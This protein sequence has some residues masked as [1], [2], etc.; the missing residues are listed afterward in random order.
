MLTC[1]FSGCHDLPRYRATWW[2]ELREWC[3]GKWVI[4]FVDYW[5]VLTMTR[6]SKP[7]KSGMELLLTLVCDNIPVYASLANGFIGPDP[8]DLSQLWW[9][10][11]QAVGKQ[12]HPN[13]QAEI[14]A[15]V[16]PCGHK[17]SFLSDRLLSF[18]YRFDM[19]ID[20]YTGL[21]I[22]FYFHLVWSVTCIKA[23]QTSFEASST[24]QQAVFLTMAAWSQH[25]LTNTKLTNYKYHIIDLRSIQDRHW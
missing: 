17:K 21:G 14:K 16:W 12:C 7:A 1:S 23:W 2:P 9:Y 11:Q 6:E 4:I 15:L 24:E 18:F 13:E 25:A 5:Q 20:G 3:S 22:S 8:V 10:R 19:P